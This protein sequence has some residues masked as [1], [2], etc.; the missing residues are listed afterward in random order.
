MQ[1]QDSTFLEGPNKQ[2]TGAARGVGLVGRTRRRRGTVIAVEWLAP[3]GWCRKK[4][5]RTGRATG[6]RCGELP[7]D[8]GKPAGPR[9][10]RRRD[11]VGSAWLIFG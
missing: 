10:S 1:E 7:G 3:T 9:G 6:Q 8:L 4:R 5:R 11:L 2:L